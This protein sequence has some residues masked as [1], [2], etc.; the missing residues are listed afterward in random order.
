MSIKIYI[1]THAKFEQPFDSNYIAIQAGKALDEEKTPYIGDNTG[2]NISA[3][4]QNFCELTVHYWMWK[5]HQ[6]TD[7]V[8]LNHYKR[9]FE[10]QNSFVENYILE[11]VN[12]SPVLRKGHKIASSNDFHEFNDGADIL[13]G[14]PQDMGNNMYTQYNACHYIGDIYLV[15]SIIKE[16]YPEYCEAF[17]F[18]M[19]KNTKLSLCNMFISKPEVFNEYSEWLFRILCTMSDMKFYKFYDSYQSRIFGFISERLMNVWLLKNRNRLCVAYRD[20]VVI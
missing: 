9:Y 3:L 17:D 1:A 15:R 5:N 19:E 12:E 2:E 6:Q 14:T 13:V 20:I 7:L 8:G 16:I 10:G 11:Y 18:F 4:N